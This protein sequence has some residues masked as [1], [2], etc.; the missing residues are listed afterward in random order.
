MKKKKMIR[1]EN[2]SIDVKLVQKSLK[3]QVRK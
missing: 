3:A 2:V 1:K